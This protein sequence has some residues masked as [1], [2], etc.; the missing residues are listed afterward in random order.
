M[1]PT[2]RIFSW[3]CCTNI[4][5]RGPRHLTQCS[6]A[7]VNATLCSS[8]IAP[9]KTEWLPT[10]TTILFCRWLLHYL[11]KIEKSCGVVFD[12]ELS[13]R[14]S[15]GDTIEV[16][17]ILTGKY[18]TNVTFGFEKYQDCR[19]RGHNLK[20]VNHRCHYE[21]RKYFFCTRI[22]NTWNSLPESVI[23]ASTTD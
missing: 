17:I 20:L 22:T 18:D 14:R 5:P 7:N 8:W 6:V 10:E 11:L 23:S 21:L 12:S 15:R 2:G 3:A 13:F 16:F 4:E 1:G 9:F 19:T